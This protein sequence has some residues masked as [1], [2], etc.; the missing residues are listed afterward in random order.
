MFPTL[1]LSLSPDKTKKQPRISTKSIPQFSILQSY[2][3]EWIVYL[4]DQ[5]LDCETNINFVGDCWNY[6]MKK[7]M[8]TVQDLIEE[9]KIRTVWWALC[10]FSV[11][12]FL[13]RMLKSLPLSL[14]PPSLSV[15]LWFSFLN[16]HLLFVQD[17]IIL[18]YTY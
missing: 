5:E 4:Y 18:D 15:C 6:N 13:T 10:I 7:A 16:D 9:A 17:S 14:P 2:I 8:D 11:S 1:Y 3:Y 12:Y